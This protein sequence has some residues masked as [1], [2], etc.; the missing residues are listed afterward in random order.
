MSP[1]QASKLR[2]TIRLVADVSTALLV[3]ILIGTFTWM[4]GIDRD[5]V[6]IDTNQRLV[7]GSVSEMATSMGQLAERMAKLEGTVEARHENR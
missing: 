4:K 3:A 2:D 1:Q 5:V 6:R 7:M